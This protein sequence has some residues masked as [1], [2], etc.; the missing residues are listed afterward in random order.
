MCS[1]HKSCEV[2]WRDPFSLLN[3]KVPLRGAFVQELGK[4]SDATTSTDCSPF[5]NTVVPLKYQEA[6]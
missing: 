6:N 5:L 3:G 1:A 4:I 2:I